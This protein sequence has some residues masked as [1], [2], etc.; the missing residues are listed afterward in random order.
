MNTTTRRFPRTLHEAFPA[1]HAE[2]ITRYGT[3]SR[4]EW[5]AGVVLAVSIGVVLAVLLVEAL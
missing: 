2:A 5:W 3:T 1:D 4:V